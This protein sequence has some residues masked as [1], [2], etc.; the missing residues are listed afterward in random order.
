MDT[1]SKAITAMRETA[2]VNVDE[3]PPRK[4]GQNPTPIR[5]FAQDLRRAFG[6]GGARRVNSMVQK[7][8]MRHSSVTTTETYYVGIN[9]DETAALPAA[10]SSSQVTLEVTH[11]K[12]ATF[13]DEETAETGQKQIG[14][15]GLEPR[16]N[17]L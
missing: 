2:G 5:A 7:E 16:T 9:A 10:I 8:L 11:R 14:L 17:G 13:Q 12:N 4:T 15:L 3:N 6:Y 1:V